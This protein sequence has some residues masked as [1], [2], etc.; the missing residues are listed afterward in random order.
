MLDTVLKLIEEFDKNNTDSTI[1]LMWAWNIDDLR[2]QI[3]V[4]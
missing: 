4:Y 3:K 1:I 2:H